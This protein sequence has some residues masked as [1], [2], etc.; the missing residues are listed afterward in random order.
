MA[1][2]AVMTEQM[3]FVGPPDMKQFLDTVAEDGGRSRAEV[4][5]FAITKTYGLTED[6][7]VPDAT[8]MDTLVAAAIRKMNGRRPAT[9]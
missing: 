9:A 6:G 8:D 1:K 2:Q 7:N 5:R 4:V 3:P